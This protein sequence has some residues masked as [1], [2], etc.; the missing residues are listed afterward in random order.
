MFFV[1]M[2]IGSKSACL[3]TRPDERLSG[4]SGWFNDMASA[5]AKTLTSMYRDS[6]LR[7]DSARLKQLTVLLENTD[8]VPVNWQNYLRNGITQLNADMDLASREN[9]VVRGLPA[10]MEGDDLIAFWKQVWGDFALAL[11]AWP[12]IRQAAA[13]HRRFK[14]I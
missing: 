5:S 13:S 11:K 6:R 2:I 9:F 12:E 8:P 14:L 10:S 1:E 7:G 3:S 4:L